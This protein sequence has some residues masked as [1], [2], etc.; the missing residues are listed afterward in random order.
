MSKFF[1]KV[2][3][4]SDIHLPSASL[5]SQED[6]FNEIKSADALILSGDIS[7]GDL[8]YFQILSKTLPDMQIY[9]VLG[10]HDFYGR[11]FSETRLAVRKICLDNN[12]LHFL[13]DIDWEMINDIPIIGHEGWYDC[14]YGRTGSILLHDFDYIKDISRVYSTRV[15]QLMIDKFRDVAME[16]ANHFKFSL[17]LIYELYDQA[18]LVTHVP[19]FPEV[20]FYNGNKCS[21]EWLPYMVSKISGD[22]LF[23]IMNQYKDKQ[24]LV[25]CGHTHGAGEA[26]ILPNL[27][28]M[29]AESVF[30]FPKVY[31]D[32]GDLSC[33]MKQK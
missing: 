4:A 29:A 23:S 2:F 26:Q 32:F 14:Y 27:K 12:N 20:A 1:N 10:N 25:L 18:I 9:F 17:D 5:K 13:S 6:F 24:L 15:F 22:M 3:W 11:T 16:S 7:N 33:L 31:K 30:K 8:K 21:T 19:P 28:V